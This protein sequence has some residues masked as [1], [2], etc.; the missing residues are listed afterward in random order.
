MKGVY[1]DIV[2]F[3]C[4]A[5]M[6]FFLYYNHFNQEIVNRWYYICFKVLEFLLLFGYSF[7]TKGLRRK[8][9]YII[10]AFFMVRIIW[11]VFELENKFYANRPYVL[12]IIFGFCMLCILFIWLAYKKHVTKNGRT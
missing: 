7:F 8:I 12:D 11:Q 6:A 10:S 5:V 9:C 4:M 2:F 3:Y 1:I